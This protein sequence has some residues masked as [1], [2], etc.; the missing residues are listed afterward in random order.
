MGHF[1]GGPHRG[2]RSLYVC[3]GRTFNRRPPPISAQCTI[4]F[5]LGGGY[6]VAAAVSRPR[7]PGCTEPAAAPRLRAAQLAVSGTGWQFCTPLSA[8]CLGRAPPQISVPVTL[9]RGA[10]PAP[11]LRSQPP[12]MQSALQGQPPYHSPSR[13]AESHGPTGLLQHASPG[14]QLPGPQL[15]T[16]SPDQHGS[17]PCRPGPPHTA[18]ASR[19]PG[20]AILYPRVQD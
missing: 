18:P 10:G 15:S 3:P 1:G 6:V 20:L 2:G 14:P 16:S 9:G 13:R 7:V 11:H 5:T 12:P 17:C 8:G 19:Q 4:F